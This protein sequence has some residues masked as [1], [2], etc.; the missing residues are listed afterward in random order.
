VIGLSRKK[1]DINIVHFFTDLTLEQDIQRAIETI[2]MQYPKFEALI[3][4][5]GVLQVQKL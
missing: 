5:A 2:K 3:N 1:P 4:C